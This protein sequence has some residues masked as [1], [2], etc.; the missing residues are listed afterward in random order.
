MHYLTDYR[1][2]P[3]ASGTATTT[4]PKETKP[5]VESAIDASTSTA[6]P[7]SRTIFNIVLS[8]IAFAIACEQERTRL[9]G[10]VGAYVPQCEAD[11]S[12]TKVQC[13]GGE[14]HLLCLE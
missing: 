14:L 5:T 11:G 2:F 9:E 8:I 7:F 3:R 4:T 12:Y 13:Y 10:L 1:D 6:S